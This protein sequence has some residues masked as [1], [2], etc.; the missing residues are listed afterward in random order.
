MKNKEKLR[1]PRKSKKNIKIITENTA[2]SVIPKYLTGIYV[3]L[4]VEDN[5]YKTK[6]SIENQIAFLKEFIEK[7]SK[8]FE[9]IQ[10]YVDNGTTGTNFDRENWNV[11]LNDIKSSAINCIIVKDFSRIGRNNIEE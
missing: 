11:L 8:E 9:L 3:R 6:D 7:N 2:S 5:G 4:S 10:I 1:M